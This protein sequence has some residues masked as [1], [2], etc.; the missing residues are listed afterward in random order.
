MLMVIVVG[1]MLKCQ[2][3]RNGLDSEEKDIVAVVEG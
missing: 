1:I 3:F 2:K